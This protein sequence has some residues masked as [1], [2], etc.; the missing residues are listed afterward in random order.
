[1]TLRPPPPPAPPP[2]LLAIALDF[3]D[4]DEAL[5]VARAVHPW[6]EIA[7][8]GLQLFTSVGPAAVGAL[9]NEG[10]EVFLDLKLHDIP[11]T[12]G[13]AAA[14]A[15]RAGA[16]LVTAHG[17]GGEQMLAAA[18]AGY[19]E[20]R[21]GGGIGWGILAVTVLTSEPNPPLG[22]VADR[23]HLALETG[24]AGVVCAA[25]E[26]EVARS[27]SEQLIVLV[28]GIRSADG[29]RH[30]QARVATAGAAARAGASVLVAGRVVTQSPD[31]AR[32]AAALA[33]EVAGAT[34]H[35]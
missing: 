21:P 30:D 1:V 28:P 12:V 10:Y 9:V 34:G 31:P 5:A 15:G 35:P 33:A 11:N 17:A 25:A 24:C 32:A 4:L 26:I 7:K 27:V 29:P 8:V 22:A 19:A 2:P 16:S 18:V 20:G 13:R 6:C 3:S 23:C 14:A